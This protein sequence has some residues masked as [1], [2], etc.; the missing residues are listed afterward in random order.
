[1]MYSNKKVF[2]LLIV[3]KVYAQDNFF[4]Q[5]AKTQ[6]IKISYEEMVLKME[7]GLS[8]T[9]LPYVAKFQAKCILY[10]LDRLSVDF[11]DANIDCY[12]NHLFDVLDLYRRKKAL[13][14]DFNLSQVLC[15]VLYRRKI[16]ELLNKDNAS[17]GMLDF[18]NTQ[19]FVKEFNQ[20]TSY[21]PEIERF[22]SKHT[23]LQNLKALFST[24]SILN[25]HKDLRKNPV[26]LARLYFFTFC[27]PEKGNLDVDGE[28]SGTVY[29]DTTMKDAIT[30]TCLL[31]NNFLN[32]RHLPC[33][34]QETI[35]PSNRIS[36][37][38]DVKKINGL[39]TDQYALIKEFTIV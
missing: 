21:V 28:I 6:H 15:E 25:E 26:S 22:E 9:D 30:Q 11:L 16:I 18:I 10:I 27:Y 23:T 12:D 4:E 32:V 13:Y 35:H 19:E 29:A 3:L 1:M 14:L 33:M 8:Y 2:L 39:V 20:D 31:F 7:R 34:T 37:L 38:Q 36:F 5:L 17:F 24:I